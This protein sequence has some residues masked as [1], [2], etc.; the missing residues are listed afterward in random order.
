[1]PRADGDLAPK[2]AWEL[3]AERARERA[4]AE[5]TWTEK[6][7]SREMVA[8]ALTPTSPSERKTR[9]TRK[10]ASDALAARVAGDA[11]KPQV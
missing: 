7:T 1:M 5:T 6:G 8:A 10:A 4:E 2:T 3:E 9:G 11:P